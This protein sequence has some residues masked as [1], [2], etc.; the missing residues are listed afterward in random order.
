MPH[1]DF[2]AA[3]RAARQDEEQPDPV[4]FVY[5]G[6][7]FTV[8]QDPSLGDVMELAAVPD[9]TPE[10]EE[11]AAMACMQFVRRML[12]LEDRQRFDQAHYTIP[13]R[14]AAPAIIALTTWLAEQVAGFP[15][16]P[17]DSSATS[18]SGSS[19][20]SSKRTGGTGRSS[21]PRRPRAS[22]SSTAA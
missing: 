18:S 22:P 19:P 5:G 1:F 8:R 10:N 6:Q 15:T 13:A 4:T 16:A 14:N 3:L 12:L 11:Q 17:P 20:T 2:D 21:K 9:P 7:E